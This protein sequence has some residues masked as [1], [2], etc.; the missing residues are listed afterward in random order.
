M[1]TIKAKGKKLKAKTVSELIKQL[2]RIGLKGK[3]IPKKGL[4]NVKFLSYIDLSAKDI[5]LQ[6]LL[7]AEQAAQEEAI[8]QFEAD[9]QEALADYQE[10][11]ITL[12]KE[13]NEMLIAA[14]EGLRELQKEEQAM[15]KA[16][17]E[18]QQEEMALLAS[19]DED[20]EFIFVP[21]KRK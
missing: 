17:K 1:Y 9:Q 12:E 8:A 18:M 3:L 6:D 15:L 7:A 10:E 20:V 4:K 2:T 21:K 5:V 13:Y 14:E 16:A 11:Q 19:L